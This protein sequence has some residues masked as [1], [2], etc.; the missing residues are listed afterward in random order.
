MLKITSAFL[1]VSM[2]ALA[3]GPNLDKVNGTWDEQAPV[4]SPD[5]KRL[6]F[7]VA[8]NEQNIGGMRDHGDIWYSALTETG[9][10]APVHAG[11]VINN[12]LHNIIAGFSSDGRQMYLMSHYSVDEHPVTSQGISVSTRTQQGWSQPQNINIPYFKNRSA[13]QSGYISSDAEV[14]VFSAD[15][16][17]SKGA[18]DIYVSTSA[19]GKWSEPVNLGPVI[20]TGEQ[21]VCPALSSDKRR[22]Y[23]S[24][25]GHRGMGSFDIFYA[26]RLDDTWKNWSKPVNLGSDINS[27]GRELYYREFGDVA[28]LT[29]TQN[30]DG[31]ADIRLL[32]R[33][34]Q[35]Q[36]PVVAA[37]LSAPKVTDSA[38]IQEI[39][40]SNVDSAMNAVTVIIGKVTNSATN[41]I[42]PGGSLQF[43]A[44]D[45]MIDV[46]ADAGGIYKA[47]LHGMRE[48]HVKVEAK[49][50]IG[51]FEKLDLRTHVM[52][53]MVMNFSLE[54]IEIGATVNLKSVLFVQSKPALLEESFDELDMVVDF[55]KL[56]PDV[57]IE[58][59]GH[60]DNRGRHDMNMKL[61]RERVDAV[62]AYL[63]SKGVESRRISGKGYGGTRP[64]ADNEAEDTRALNRRV[65]FT[66]M[67]E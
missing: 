40:Y 19:G 17:G 6:Y 42:I 53:D 18:E 2:S 66:I 54:P 22:L 60:T 43:H 15:S 50:F 7:T 26:D 3:Q 9:W 20:N 23:F 41:E 55:M 34:M 59:A 58:L 13:Y 52:K 12:T 64:I 10:S 45:K 8:S 4:L 56:N 29:S 33:P 30:S 62:K 25:N 63:V 47:N 49:G 37:T 24:S 36:Q 16:Y 32:P 1:L 11:N 14:L 44:G 46:L 61:S 65:E 67:K 35:T 48:Y 57:S 28:Y 27:E 38:G 39:K 51:R 21:D 5:G 31:Y